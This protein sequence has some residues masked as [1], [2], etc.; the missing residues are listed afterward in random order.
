MLK[1]EAKTKN[2]K[3]SDLLTANIRR[4]GGG[5]IRLTA[6][7]LFFNMGCV[8]AEFSTESD[9]SAYLDT[10]TETGMDADTEESDT[11]SDDFST[12][13]GETDTLTDTESYGDTETFTET[14]EDTDQCPLDDQKTAPG[15]CGCGVPDTDS[16]GDGTPDC[17]DSC[18]TDPKKTEP[19]ICGCFVPDDECDNDPC[20]GDPNKTDPGI[21][22]CGVPDTDSDGDGAADC[23]DDCPNDPG[24]TEPG[25]CGCG[26]AE[27]ICQ[28]WN[29]VYEAENRTSDQNVS[30]SS[31]NTGYLG[32]GYMDYGGAGAFVEWNNVDIPAAATYTLEFRYT[33]AFYSRPCNLFINGVD[34]AD[35]PFGGVPG[36]TWSDWTTNTLAIF[37]PAGTVTI[38]VESIESGPNLD[39]MTI[40]WKEGT[41]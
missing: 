12:E 4:A 29:W 33:T 5:C 2:Q 8:T 11:H 41:Q 37:L 17:K 35:I 31:A 10:N 14:E 22:G 39:R 28:N 36:A 7:A 32:T 23:I 20:P 21:C 9:T 1:K 24:K 19:G 6:V 34:S 27:G 30:F 26:I 16:D 13:S 15:V 38:R 40:T 18:L 25:V 3:I